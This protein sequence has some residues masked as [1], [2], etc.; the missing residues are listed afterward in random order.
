MEEKDQPKVSLFNEAQ[1]KGDSENA[2]LFEDGTINAPNALENFTGARTPWEEKSS[3]DSKNAGFAETLFTGKGISPEGE[4][5]TSEAAGPKEEKS[6]FSNPSIKKL[7]SSSA[8]KKNSSL[9]RWIR[10]IAIF[11]V[12]GGICYS[13]ITL[14]PPEKIKKIKVQ[15]KEWLKPGT[16][17]QEYIPFEIPGLG[18]DETEPAISAPS[19]KSPAPATSPP[20]AKKV[21]SQGV[22]SGDQLEK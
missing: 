7:K 5:Q 16:V 20:V 12:L 15:V 8:S 4:Q 22:L 21:N 14:T 3:P 1:E 2:S 18:S 11:A 10:L 17:L 9:L 19:E 13:A 6:T